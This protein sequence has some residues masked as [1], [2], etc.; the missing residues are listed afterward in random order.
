MLKNPAVYSTKS[1]ATARAKRRVLSNYKHD[2]CNCPINAQIRLLIAN[3]FREFCYSFDE[4]YNCTAHDTCLI[5]EFSPVYKNMLPNLT[6]RQTD[7]IYTDLYK[8]PIII[9]TLSAK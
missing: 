5:N 6:N 7:K 4:S 1:T 8:L 9:E 2:V 3:H